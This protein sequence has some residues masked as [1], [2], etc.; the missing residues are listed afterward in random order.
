VGTTTVRAVETVADSGGTL[1]PG[2]GVTDI[3]ITPDRGV[4]AVD[5]IV[6]GWHEAGVSHLALVEAVGTGPL[7]ARCY[8]A[9][10]ADGYLWHE[11][12][13]SLLLLRR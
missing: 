11:F 8:A 7:V 2:S 4:R 1:H 13:D 3:L 5:G 6:T 12:G 10:V 9:A